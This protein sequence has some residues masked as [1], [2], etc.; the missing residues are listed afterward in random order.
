MNRLYD[1]VLT[2]KFKKQYSKIKK[3]SNFD[4]E[5]LKK[6]IDILRKNELMP[7]K[8]KNH[9]L[10]PKSKSI[11]ECHIQPDVLLEYTKNDKELILLLI[12]IGSHSDLFK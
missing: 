3:R 4:K 8:Y 11:W 2:N 5:E 6:V 1:V 10:I 7:P 12:S 9:L